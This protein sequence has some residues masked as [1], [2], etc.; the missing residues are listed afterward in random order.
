M[1]SWAPLAPELFDGF[2]ERRTRRQRARAT[3]RRLDVGRQRLLVTAA[4]L[5]RPITSR[6]RG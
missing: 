4:R 1:N 3:V 2:H 5:A 6:L